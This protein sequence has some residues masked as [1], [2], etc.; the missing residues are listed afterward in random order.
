MN[1]RKPE[2]QEKLAAAYVLGTLRGPARQRFERLMVADA[3]IRRSVAEWETRLAPLNEA[4]QPVH[5]PRKVWRNIKARL[6]ALRPAPSPWSWQGLALWRTLAGGLATAAIVL[7]VI[8]VQLANQPVQVQYVA[9]LQDPA[10]KVAM[11][12]SAAGIDGKLR[13][14]SMQG[15]V[16]SDRDLELWAL[17]EGG[18]PQSLGV[19]GHRTRAELAATARRLANVPALAISLEP[20]GGSPTGQPTGPVLYSGKLLAM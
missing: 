11:V 10:A 2:L 20:K 5:P 19:V 8:S 15:G 4:V 7:A 13:V 12:V 18:K 17:P 6:R 1:Y 14:Q 9:V 16:P 3:A